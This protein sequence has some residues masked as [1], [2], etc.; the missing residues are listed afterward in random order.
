MIEAQEPT[1]GEVVK[2]ETPTRITTTMI[3]ND[4]DNGIDRIGIQEKYGLEKWEVTQ[5]F[6]HPVLKGKKAKKVK[7]LSFEFVDDSMGDPNQTSIPVETGS[8]TVE[9]VLEHEDVETVEEISF[10]EE[11]EPMVD[12]G[13][14][15][16]DVDEIEY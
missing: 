5:M 1:D 10:D 6:Q 2:Q 8:A 16:E 12:E 7:K 3:L 13:A 11:D 9:E 15:A 14:Y 4:L